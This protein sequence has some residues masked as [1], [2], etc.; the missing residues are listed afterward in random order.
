[1]VTFLLLCSPAVTSGTCSEFVGDVEVIHQ[2]QTLT[3]EGKTSQRGK[4]DESVESSGAEVTYHILFCR[5]VT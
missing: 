1:M 4:A 5:S 3:P 2:E